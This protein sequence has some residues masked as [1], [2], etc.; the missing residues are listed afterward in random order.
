MVPAITNAAPVHNIGIST[1]LEGRVNT[2]MS[3]L[4]ALRTTRMSV[5]LNELTWLV[6]LLT[7][8]AQNNCDTVFKIRGG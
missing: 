6:N 4:T 2:L 3:I 7:P 8:A 1:W 5:R